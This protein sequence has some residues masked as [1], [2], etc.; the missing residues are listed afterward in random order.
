[1]EF[2]SS[3]ALPLGLSWFAAYPQAVCEFP[4]GAKMMGLDWSEP[5][6]VAESCR[7]QRSGVRRPGVLG[8]ADSLANVI[9]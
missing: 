3:L 2:E 7:D 9:I 5:K 6:A 4:R 8:L 1:M